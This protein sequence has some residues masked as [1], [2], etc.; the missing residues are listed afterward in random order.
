[1]SDVRAVIVGQ[2]PYPDAGL[3]N[4]VAFS[5]PGAPPTRAL[6]A[7]FANLEASGPDLQFNRPIPHNGDLTSWAHRGILMLNASLTYEA[8]ELDAHC[9]HWKPLLRALLLAVSRKP[10]P[11]PFLLLGGRAVDLMSS[12][13]RP[14]AR[15]MTGHP[16]PRNKQATR[17]PLFVDD[18]A[19]LR[20]NQFLTDNGADPIDWSLT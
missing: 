6:K 17:F 18:R 2:D 20:A 15:I 10:E 4:G 14:D 16:T 11:I 8:G 12:V 13:T 3:A 1:M 5:A 9:Q 19:F 7:I